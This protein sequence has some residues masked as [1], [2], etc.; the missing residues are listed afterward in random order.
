MQLLSSG[1][2]AFCQPMSLIGSPA[3]AAGVSIHLDDAFHC[4]DG[5]SGAG[6]CC[7]NK[8]AHTECSLNGVDATV[9]CICC[10]SCS[11]YIILCLNVSAE[12]ACTQQVLIAS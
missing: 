4:L 8:T 5:W 2:A 3:A 11:D 6:A 10:P 7:Y 12:K 9:D 1:A